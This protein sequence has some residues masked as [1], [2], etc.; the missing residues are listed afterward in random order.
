MFE[1]AA[2][3]HG[4]PGREASRVRRTSVGSES[5]IEC[6]Q[7]FECASKHTF[8]HGGPAAKVAAPMSPAISA[9]A[10]RRRRLTASP[11]L[12]SG[13]ALFVGSY[14]QKNRKNGGISTC[15]DGQPG[16]IAADALSLPA[17]GATE[18]VPPSIDD[19][20]PRT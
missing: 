18:A 19:R 13:L 9:D 8:H 20:K 7:G 15:R 4:S 11:S 16:C 5:Q 6:V 17:T 10:G 3:R 12:L 14:R 1:P 2:S